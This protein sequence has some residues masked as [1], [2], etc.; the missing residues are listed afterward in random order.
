MSQVP[1]RTHFWII[2]ENTNSSLTDI[3]ALPSNTNESLF[4]QMLSYWQPLI[5]IHSWLYG[6]SSVRILHLQHSILIRQTQCEFICCISINIHSTQELLLNQ[7]YTQ[8]IYP[9]VVYV[10]PNSRFEET[11]R[12]DDAGQANHQLHEN[13]NSFDT[14]RQ[15]HES[16]NR[17]S[18]ER[19]GSDL[20]NYPL[21]APNGKFVPS[22]RI[23]HLDLKG[24]AYR[25]GCEEFISST[26][27]ANLL[28]TPLWFA[29]ADELHGYF[30]G[31]G[32][33]VSIHGTTNKSSQRLRV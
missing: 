27:L 17:G 33:H 5:S 11:L 3:F 7:K 16:L 9:E 30:D 21:L 20:S 29:Q 26:T 18:L 4:A 24:G 1:L 12:R 19:V 22:R 8:K 25:V 15:H 14:N 13:S 32:R 28:P 31:V 6:P 23:V 10:R 2:H